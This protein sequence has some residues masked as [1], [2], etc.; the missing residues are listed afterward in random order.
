MYMLS[1]ISTHDEMR[2]MQRAGI[3][4]L[5]ILQAA[6]INAAKALQLDASLG[7]VS[8]GKEADLLLVR[9]NPLDDIQHLAEPYAVIKAGSW[10]DEDKLSELSNIGESPSSWFTG[11]GYFIE[12]F[13]LRKFI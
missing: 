3:G 11:F 8:I 1:G 13:V 10:L 9:Q 5:S 6:T 2:L 7:R 12:D 4:T